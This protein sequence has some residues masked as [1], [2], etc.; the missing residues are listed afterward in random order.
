MITEKYGL[1]TF[2]DNDNADLPAY[3]KTMNE[4]IIK[5]LDNNKGEKGD[6]GLQGPKGDPGG[7]N[8]VNG[9][10]GDVIG[11]ATKQE[12]LNISNHL[13]RTDIKAN[14][15]AGGEVTLPC[16]YKVG[17]DCLKVQY[18]TE[19]LIKAT[20]NDTQGHYYE[21][22]AVN[23]ISNKIKITSDWSLEV[24]DVLIFIVQGVYSV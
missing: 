22:G 20:D 8:S 24:G 11:I 6:T 5:A 18:E 19:T 4:A 10:Q 17:T 12:I 21:V 7:V 23:S 13:Y 3:S 9:M 15:A 2:E 16:Y 1:K 14:I